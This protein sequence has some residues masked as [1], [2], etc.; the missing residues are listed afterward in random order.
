MKCSKFSIPCSI[1]VQDGPEKMVICMLNTSYWHIDSDLLLMIQTL[2]R[3]MEQEVR[4]DAWCLL[5]P[6][7][8]TRTIQILIPEILQTCT[9]MPR[10]LQ[11][12]YYFQVNILWH[13]LETAIYQG[14]MKSASVPTPSLPSPSKHHPCIHSVDH[15]LE[16]LRSHCAN[17]P[18]AIAIS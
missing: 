7:G 14:H 6:V 11:Y 18:H 8:F 4:L 1:H 3:F 12:H 10:E 9:V 16:S 5:M 15:E 13:H 17:I 2:L